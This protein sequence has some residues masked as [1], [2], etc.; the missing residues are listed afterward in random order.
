MDI[1]NVKSCVKKKRQISLLNFNFALI[2][3]VANMVLEMYIQE[4]DYIATL[5]ITF[6][7]ELCQCY[8]SI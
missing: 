7:T 8:A 4:Q 3:F 5:H 1:D 6:Q 2:Y